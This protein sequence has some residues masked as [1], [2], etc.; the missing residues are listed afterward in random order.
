MTRKNGCWNRAPLRETVRTQDGWGEA[1]DTRIPAMRT[2]PV[3]MTKDCQYTLITSAMPETMM[4]VTRC[5][6]LVKR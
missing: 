6:R 5:A 4:C 1:G 2:Y 3:P